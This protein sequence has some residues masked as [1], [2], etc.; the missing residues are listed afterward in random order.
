MVQQ[1][2]EGNKLEGNCPSEVKERRSL[3][4]TD[5]LP[6]SNDPTRAILDTPQ[7]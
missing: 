4:T 6:P 3:I 1:T 7:M 2:M 5:C